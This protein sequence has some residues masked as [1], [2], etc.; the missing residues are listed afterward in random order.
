MMVVM[1]GGGGEVV[2]GGCFVF[3]LYVASLDLRGSETRDM[4]V[5]L[6]ATNVHEC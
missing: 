4:V 5:L 3:K 1:G 6:V 2:V